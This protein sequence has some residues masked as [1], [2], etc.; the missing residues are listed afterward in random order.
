LGIAG[1]TEGE[2]AALRLAYAT[3]GLLLAAALAFGAL[4]GFPEG[5]AF[6]APVLGG[7]SIV[8]LAL[9]SSLRALRRRVE[10]LERRPPPETPAA[11]PPAGYDPGSRRAHP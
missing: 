9:E 1:R 6:Y 7:F 11:P 4:R 8:L 5:F 3:C 10:S 2:S